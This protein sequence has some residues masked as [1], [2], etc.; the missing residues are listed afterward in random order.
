MNFKIPGFALGIGL[1]R[2]F[3]SDGGCPRN[4]ERCGRVSPI[5]GRITNFSFEV[6]STMLLYY[7]ITSLQ[8]LYTKFTISNSD[9]KRQHEVNILF[10]FILF[11]FSLIAIAFI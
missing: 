5:L 10:S 4:V 6:S 7:L 8:H 3:S 1:N 9:L 11:F 2:T